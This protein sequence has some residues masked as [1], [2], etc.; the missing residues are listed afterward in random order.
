MKTKL[1]C[2]ISVAGVAAVSVMATDSLTSTTETSPDKANLS[3]A[4]GMRM[5][6]Q[7]MEAGTNVDENVAIQAVADVLEH[8]PTMMQE[9]QV[10]Q[11]LNDARANK[12]APKDPVK[13]SYA[14]GMRAASMIEHSGIE[15]D[16]AVVVQAMED[17]AQGKPKMKQSE[18]APL[19]IQAVKY[20]AVEK[21]QS[22]KAD[23]AAFLTKNAKNPGIKVLPDGLQY[24]V[25]Q[26]GTGPYA[27]PDDLIY[28]KFRGTFIN[29]VEFDQHPHFLTRTH[30]GLK[31]WSDVLPK[32]RVGS[33]W[34]I[35][36]SPDLAFGHRGE[37]YHGVAP[38][39]TVIYDIK[40]VSI[41]PPGGNYEIS[42]GVGH[43]LD[44]GASAPDS[45]STQ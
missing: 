28:V 7:L 44:V 10:L 35:Y 21:Q 36:A 22:N 1:L 16:P 30:N 41:A 39:S 25:L 19:F 17:V 37:S 38:D 32:M 18:I 23:G 13:F 2:A 11:I 20:A 34:R 45:N 4:M 8:K 29:G 3:Y 40:L 6:M 24:Q 26:D 14:G 12:G 42:S 31:A 5:G 9:S 43:G 33:E 15:V 27:K